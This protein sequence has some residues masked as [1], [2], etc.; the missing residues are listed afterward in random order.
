MFAVK[1]LK[2]VIAQ[3]MS[4]RYAG[5]NI[6]GKGSNKADMYELPEESKEMEEYQQQIQNLESE[7]REEYLESKRNKSRLS[8]SHR[9]ILQGSAPYEGT[10]FQYSNNHRSR[11]FKRGLL[12]RYGTKS[13]VNPG[14][15]WPT[16]K[17]LDL[18]MTNR[19]SDLIWVFFS[20]FTRMRV[21]ILSLAGYGFMLNLIAVILSELKAEFGYDVNPEDE[22]MKNRIAEREKVLVKEERERKKAAR[23]EKEKEMKMKS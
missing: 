11:K 13:G 7:V 12:G 1:M 18:G 4:V 20:F 22:I 23:A 6:F 2:V 21:F 14:I 19:N 8:A 10:I 5:W 15:A 16:E 3:R 9:Q 17:D